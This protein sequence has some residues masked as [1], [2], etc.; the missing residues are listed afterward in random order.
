MQVFQEGKEK[1]TVFDVGPEEFAKVMKEIAE[2]GVSALGGCWGTTCAHIK[3][4]RNAV[5]TFHSLQLRKQKFTMVSSYSHA[6]VGN[7]RIIIG[8]RIKSHREKENERGTS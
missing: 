5:L 4:L 8:E 7:K 6:E 1:R 3:A 2:M